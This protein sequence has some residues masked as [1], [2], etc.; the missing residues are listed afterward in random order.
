MLERKCDKF[1]RPT[2]ERPQPSSFLWAWD[3]VV[4]VIATRK[5]DKLTEYPLMLLLE[6]IRIEQNS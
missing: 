5:D 6:M 1:L 2:I 3:H 4:V